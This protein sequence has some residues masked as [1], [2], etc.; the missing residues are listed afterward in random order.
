MRSLKAVLGEEC[1]AKLQSSH[2]FI[3]G[4]G[5]I[6]CE[7]L[8]VLPKIGVRRMTILDLD[9]IEE[10]NL[11]RQFYFRKSD[12]KKYKAAVAKEKLMELHPNLEIVALCDSIYNS[13]YDVAF[14]EQFDCVIA[15]IDSNRGRRY[16]GT[17][18]VKA[19]VP[20][21]DGGTK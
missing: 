20:M 3:V 8:K 12:V 16:V 6:G 5:G 7:L 11:N 21:V 19:K 2:L 14:Y 17:M 4:V 1:V 10:T 13:K 9:I 18:C 15:A